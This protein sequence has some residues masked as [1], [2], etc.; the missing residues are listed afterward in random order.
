ME[1]GLPAADFGAGAVG[2]E[3]GRAP[4]AE[5]V[6]GDRTGGVGV[7]AQL[8]GADLTGAERLASG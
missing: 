6:G 3:A 8:V 1:V 5:A 7:E 2:D 4:G